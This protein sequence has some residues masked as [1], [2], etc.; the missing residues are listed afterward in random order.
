MD[1]IKY[2]YE[3]GTKIFLAGG[4]LGFDTLAAQAVIKCQKAYSDIQ[5]IIIAPCQDQDIFWT[6]EDKNTYA[7]IKKSAN[8]V[9]YLSEHYYSG[10]MHDRNRYLVDNSSTCICYKVRQSGGTAFTVGYAKNNGLTVFNLA[11]TKR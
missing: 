7:E 1:G 3:H 6:W 8:E 11:H 4:A 5:L 2:L 9:I 10:C